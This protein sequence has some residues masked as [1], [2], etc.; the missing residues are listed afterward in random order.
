MPS[1]I[2][3]SSGVL[4]HPTSL[5]G[6]FGV[7]DLGSVAHDWIDALAAAGQTW[8]QVLP[9]GPTGY[10]DSPYQS[11]S[12][13]AGNMNLISPE[14]LREWKLVGSDDVAKCEL[15][16]GPV[17]YH[18]VIPRK[19]ELVRSAWHWFKAGTGAA[20]GPAFNRFRADAAGWLDD[21]AL[22]M[23][24]KDAFSG[25]PWW[26]WPRG[27]ALRQ[28]PDLRAAAET[29]ADDV[30]FYRFGQF[31][32]ARQWDELRAYA[33]ERGVNVIGDLPIYVAADSADVWAN[34]DLF[35]L[36]AGH[37]PKY[38]AGVPPDYFSKTGQ[39]WGNP[40]YEWGAHLRQRFKWW[41]DRMAA[42]CGLFDLVRL[43][44]F[45]GVERYW[46]VPAGH[47]TARHGM[48][49]PGP[50]DALLAALEKRLD[51]L[52]I[53]AEDLGLVTPEAEALRERFGLPGMRVLQ[54]AFGG[55][56][57]DRFLPH[58]FDRNLVVYTG[59][60][61]ND[62]T[63]GWY[64]NLTREER[65]RYSQYTPEAKT[66]PVWALTRLAWASVADLAVVPLQDLLDL[67]SE[68][69]INT[70]GTMAGNWR[71]RARDRDVA[72][73]TTWVGRLREF[74]TTYGRLT[75]SARP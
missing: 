67:G 72:A 29:F 44:H 37:R 1:R 41:G 23:A 54:F 10:G 26:E 25:A 46:S 11:P 74:T 30:D 40:I 38:V 42:A 48:W 50:S 35:M 39:L 13:F 6:P 33:H 7:G 2:L 12:T 71:W 55:A 31:L 20:L 34:P 60:H 69:R 75:R 3:R 32:F 5:P 27:L 18:A 58:V 51:G 56:V 59:T 16:P 63:R 47:P 53:I 19:Q 68:A 57:E 22:F 73:G 9:V 52:P 24:L 61:D 65:A 45:L 28:K 62:T 66:D 43:D 21:F 64:E 14:R 15:P 70:P 8:W 17:T 49:E 36:D 4:L